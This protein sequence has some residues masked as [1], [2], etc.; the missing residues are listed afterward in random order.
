VNLRIRPARPDDVETLRALIA[1]MGYQVGAEELRARLEGLPD[2]HA[3]YLAESGS[4]GLGWG[5]VQ[6]SHSL[7][8]GPRAELAGLAVSA[9]AQGLGVGSALLSAVEE[10]AA[11]RGVRKMYLRSGTERTEAHSFYLA[12]GYER[13]KTQ[14]ALTKTLT[15]AAGT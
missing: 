6:I 15:P 5:H 2:G 13:V 14:L 8:A 4:E 3:V 12:R 9:R 11:R 1:T 10:W 7:I